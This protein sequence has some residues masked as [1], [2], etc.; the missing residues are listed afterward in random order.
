M[1]HS[2]GDRGHT[3]LSEHNAVGLVM[4]PSGQ[5][6]LLMSICAPCFA[7][8]DTQLTQKAGGPCAYGEKRLMILGSTMLWTSVCLTPR[9]VCM[10]LL[11]AAGQDIWES[12]QNIPVFL[13]I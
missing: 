5:P 11:G 13:N 7:C 8:L 4:S 10:F 2:S 12:F 6:P 9:Q 1:H 3:L